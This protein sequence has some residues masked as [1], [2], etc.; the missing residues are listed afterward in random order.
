MVEGITAISIRGYKSLAKECSIEVRPLTILAGPNSSGK[1]SIMQPLLLM[2]QTLE[3]SYDPGPLKISGP[4]VEYTLVDQ[5]LSKLSGKKNMNDFEIS[6]QIDG[7]KSITEI[8]R[9]EHKKAIELV[10]MV[11][12]DIGQEPRLGEEIELRL[13]MDTAQI[14][15]SNPSF[16]KNLK[17]LKRIFS[18]E[19]RTIE[20]KVKRNRCFL[21]PIAFFVGDEGKEQELPILFAPI[22]EAFKKTIREL[23]HVPALRGNPRRNYDIAAVGTAFPGTFEKYMASIVNEWQRNNDSRLDDLGNS[24]QMLGLTWKVGSKPVD[25]TSVEILVGRLQHSTRGGSKDL[26]SIADVGFGVSQTLPV[27]VALL[28]ARPG[29]LVYIEQPEIHLHPRAQIAMSKILTD[30]ANR[31]VRV[32]V[33]TH[34]SLLLLG[35]QSQVAEGNLDPKNIKLHWFKRRPEDGI[36]EIISADLDEAGAFG[37]WPE[38]FA[39]VELIE[40]SRY[41]DAAEQ[42]LRNR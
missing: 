29:Q 30:A 5:F 11:Y 4:N 6:I 9:K 34:S 12:K 16:D 13:G 20:L 2:K 14:I 39:D 35:I 42:H 38:D 24:L 21:E 15:S 19:Q 23:I 26:V 8:F 3:E 31:G 40:Q 7:V 27:L 1:S 25:D 33:E 36:T 32:V 28:A 18:K 22:S 17:R 37:D 10:D 41:M